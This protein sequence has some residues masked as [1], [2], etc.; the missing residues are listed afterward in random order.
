MPAAGDQSIEAALPRRLGI[1]VKP[2]WIVAL[3]ELND[4]RFADLT[5]ARGYDLARLELCR[6]VKT[7]L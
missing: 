6:T 7:S 3:R 4:F 5:G 1:G 2:L